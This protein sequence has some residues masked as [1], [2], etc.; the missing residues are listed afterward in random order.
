MIG[1][2]DVYIEGPAGPESLDFAVRAIRLRWPR[3]IFENAETARVYSRYNQLD[4]E[5][6]REVLVYRNMDAFKSWREIGADDPNTGT[7]IHLLASPAELTIVIDED[8]TSEITSLVT[9]IRD[10]L[11]RSR[12]IL[13]QAV[14]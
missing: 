11:G 12:S 10:G 9:A 8:P 5:G 4:F 13:L 2:Q 3:A 6:L 1:R 14:A 7:L